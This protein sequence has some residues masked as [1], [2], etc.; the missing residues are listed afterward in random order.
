MGTY[1]SIFNTHIRNY[2]Q[3]KL[4]KLLWIF[5]VSDFFKNDRN[6]NKIDSDPMK[7]WI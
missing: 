5:Y 1:A 4:I 7:W 6:G 3:D 2:S